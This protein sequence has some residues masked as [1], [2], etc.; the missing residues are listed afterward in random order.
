MRNK[1]LIDNCRSDTSSEEME[2]KKAIEM[3][4]NLMSSFTK[5]K[6]KRKEIGQKIRKNFTEEENDIPNTQDVKEF[7]RYFDET[8]NIATILTDKMS[9]SAF[10]T[11]KY[12]A[13]EVPNIKP[14]DF[15]R[16]LNLYGELLPPYIPK[17]HDPVIEGVGGYP[18]ADNS[19]LK[20]EDLVAGYINKVL[21]LGMVKQCKINGRNPENS[22]YYIVDVEDRK[23]K[24]AW[25]L[26][27]E[28]YPLPKYKADPV[29]HKH[30]IFRKNTRVLAMYPQTTCFF[31]AIVLEKPKRSKDKYTV[32]F[33]NDAQKGDWSEPMEI[34]Q[35]FVL[36]CKQFT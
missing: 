7:S 10:E 12:A 23:K 36:P 35:A 4:E 11:F 21:C 15:L 28:L 1:K 31:N 3:I 6:V 26:R 20:E 5:F 25:F 34:P 24:G 19:I 30:A 18:L 33:E 22:K 17:Y 29:C 9:K 27:G 16:S 2:E 8:Y 14:A 13:F 32:I